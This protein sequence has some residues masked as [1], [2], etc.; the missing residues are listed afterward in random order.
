MI[1]NLKSVRDEASDL[2]V[3]VQSHLLR[4]SV[5]HY[6]TSDGT[7]WDSMPLRKELRDATFDM[8]FALVLI[9]NQVLSHATLSVQM[10]R[11]GLSC[12]IILSSKPQHSRIGIHYFVLCS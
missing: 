11:L 2:Y 3:E 5:K 4:A 12:D 6:L 8:S 9:V 1:E 7:L 10:V